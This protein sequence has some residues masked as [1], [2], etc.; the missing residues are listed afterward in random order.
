MIG[1]QPSLN[2]LKRH[3]FTR[4]DI[5]SLVS[6]EEY[7]ITGEFINLDVNFLRVV[8]NHEQE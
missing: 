5:V 7:L 3:E 4:V 1:T 2:Q 6:W 8:C